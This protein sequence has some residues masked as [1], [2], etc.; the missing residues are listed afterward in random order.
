[1]KVLLIS[2]PSELHLIFFGLREKVS[3]SGEVPM[4]ILQEYNIMPKRN[5][6]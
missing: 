5:K 4:K 2:N 3:V 1:V 6:L